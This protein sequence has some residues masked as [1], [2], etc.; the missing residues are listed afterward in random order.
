V[1]WSVN[2]IQNSFLTYISHCIDKKWH[3]IIDSPL[4]TATIAFSLQRTFFHTLLFDFPFQIANQ[5]GKIYAH[6]LLVYGFRRAM[7]WI[8]MTTDQYEFAWLMSLYI[9]LYTLHDDSVLPP[10]LIIPRLAYELKTSV[11]NYER[12][13]N[14]LFFIL[15]V[16]LRNATCQSCLE[17][18]H[19]EGFNSINR[20]KGPLQRPMS[21]FREDSIISQSLQS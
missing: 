7:L 15:K 4:F 14:D 2:H 10:F 11:M 8:I 6:F 18:R 9:P 16:A 20:D 17:T 5:E 1:P 3:F 12:L 21:P 19:F 13:L